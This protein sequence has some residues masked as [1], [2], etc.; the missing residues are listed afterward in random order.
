MVDDTRLEFRG[1]SVNP[2]KSVTICTDL[3]IFENFLVP[4]NTALYLY[5][6]ISKG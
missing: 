1:Q 6:P 3:L 5:V 4:L 2:C